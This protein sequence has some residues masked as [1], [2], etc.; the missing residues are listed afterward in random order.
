MYRQYTEAGIAI[1]QMIRNVVTQWNST[2][3]LLQCAI[4]LKDVLKI[5]VLKAEYNK[6]YG[7]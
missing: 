2:T 5:L 7:V 1:K 6:P 4:E 3:E